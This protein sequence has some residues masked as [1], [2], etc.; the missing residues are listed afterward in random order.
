MHVS[1]TLGAM[2]VEGKH[3]VVKSGTALPR[4]CVKTGEPVEDDPTTKTLYWA[5]PWVFV[6]IL[7]NLL[8]LLIVYLVVRKSCRLTYS[9]SAEEKRKR[10]WKLAA[11]VV[12]MV[13]SAGVFLW[14]VGAE[15]P[16]VLAGAVG[17][18]VGL[19]LL[20]A[21]SNTVGI[22]KHRDGEFWIKGC[23]PAF[24]DAVKAQALAGYGQ[25]PRGDAS[26]AGAGR[27]C[28][29]IF[30]PGGAVAQYGPARAMSVIC[31]SGLGGV[32]RPALGQQAARGLAHVFHRVGLVHDLQA[33]QRLDAVFL[34]D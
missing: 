30:R 6:F 34:R 8:I 26:R 10:A 14:G 27:E 5:P 24:L 9:L 23:G 32:D 1:L 33:Q 19:I 2:R 18:L 20:V 11:T 22:A 15:S 3:V 31:R 17:F 29:G 12:L 28:R 25:A 7:V 21:F 4:F 16:L 13:L